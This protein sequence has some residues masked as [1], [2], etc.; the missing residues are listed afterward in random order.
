MM[1]LQVFLMGLVFSF[2]GSIPPG[3][4]NMIVLQLGLERKIDTAF[5]FALAVA[6]VEYPYAWIGV[7]FEYWLT[8]SP[9]V[10]KN[11]QLITAIVMLTM[12]VL[13]L[14]PRREER[15]PGKFTE[16]GFRRGLVLSILN[17]MAIPYWMAFT[18]YMKAQHW[19]ELSTPALLHSYVFGTSVGA[20]S[21]L[22]LFIFLSNRMAGYSDKNPWVRRTPG[23][24]LLLLGF[25]ALAKYLF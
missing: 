10:V 23:I 1:Y 17:P 4:L 9:M 25:F 16:S 14:I 13:G 2:V 8:S 21:L 6:I 19:I 7:Q 5:R 11:F 15:K 3:T 12:G 22:S 20:F 24:I 18:A